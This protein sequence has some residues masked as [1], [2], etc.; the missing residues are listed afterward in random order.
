MLTLSSSILNTIFIFQLGKYLTGK[1]E[2]THLTPNINTHLNYNVLLFAL[3]ILIISE[4][5]RIGV[6]IQEEQ[7]LFV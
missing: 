3:L 1:I 4:V 2:M 5:F 7:R 6:K